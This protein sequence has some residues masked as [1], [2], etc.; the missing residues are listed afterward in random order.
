[1]G[2][3]K[4]LQ[5][6]Q[7]V[8]RFDT[9][10]ERAYAQLRTALM[11]GSFL[12]GQKLTIRKL[13]ALLGISATPARDA[14]SRLVSERILETDANRNVSVPLPDVERLQEIY[15]VRI[16]LEGP[17]AALGTPRL[18]D[19]EIDRLER[20]QTALVDAMDRKDYADVLAN[21]RDFHFTIYR[22]S[23]VELL[24]QTIEQLWLKLGPSLNLLYPAYNHSRT[25]VHNHRDVLAGLRRRDGAA[26]RAAIEQDLKDGVIELSRSLTDSY[27]GRSAGAGAG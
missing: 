5:S 6:V 9:L 14:I 13:A 16:A 24:N 21:N 7:P 4:V 23:G 8:E 12:P 3:A 22:A 25:G 20:I 1:M 18:T 19:D 2:R 11:N 26:V 27:G 15:V 17:A 10:A